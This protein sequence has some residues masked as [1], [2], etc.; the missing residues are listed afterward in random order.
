M[1]KE[2]EEKREDGL[3][4]GGELP[5]VGSVVSVETRYGT[6]EGT[7]TSSLV[8][9]NG[10]WLVYVKPQ[11]YP[12]TM[13]TNALWEINS[14]NVPWLMI[15]EGEKPTAD[16]VA[17]VTELSVSQNDFTEPATAPLDLHSVKTLDDLIKLVGDE[18]ASVLATTSEA[19]IEK[20]V[21]DKIKSIGS[22]SRSDIIS[23]LS[24]TEPEWVEA[25]A[26][27]VKQNKVVKTGAKRGTRYQIS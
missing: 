7:V 5:V 11:E 17:V 6:L 20:N 1:A 24:I 27:L 14:L 19:I 23:A 2:P 10:Q 4:I 16:S 26:S 25:I 13:Q 21:L 15:K 3:I 8:R 12:I 22:A 18:G 9:L